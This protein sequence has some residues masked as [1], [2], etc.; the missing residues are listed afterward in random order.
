MSTTKNNI[1][2]LKLGA[3]IFNLDKSREIAPLIPIEEDTSIPKNKAI[4]VPIML[5]SYNLSVGDNYELTYKGKTYS[6]IVAGFFETNYYGTVSSGYLKYYL[7]NESYETLYSDVGRATI[8]SARF[9]AADE[10]IESV[11]EEFAKDSFKE[12]YFLRWGI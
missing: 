8:L 3:S 5:K 9:K 10:D 7:P 2:S 6:F 4:Y 1:N 11:S 12:I